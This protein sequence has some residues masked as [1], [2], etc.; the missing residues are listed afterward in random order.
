M[1]LPANVRVY[2]AHA[3]LLAT[4]VAEQD[5]PLM[6]SVEKAGVAH[7]FTL[8]GADGDAAG[9]DCPAQRQLELGTFDAGRL[10]LGGRAV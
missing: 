4:G 10:K 7:C 6:L 3:N 2:D 1:L 5:K 9:G 8:N